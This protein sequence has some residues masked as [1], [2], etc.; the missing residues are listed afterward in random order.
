MST[1]SET[2]F[3]EWED[4]NNLPMLTIA[5]NVFNVKYYIIHISLCVWSGI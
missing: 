1:I 2:D 4:V 3:K 5:G